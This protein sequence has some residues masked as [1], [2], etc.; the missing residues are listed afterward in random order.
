ML[1]DHE[2]EIIK[3]KKLQTPSFIAFKSD[4]Q[5]ATPKKQNAYT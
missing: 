4:F 5:P 3:R 2:R 1:Q